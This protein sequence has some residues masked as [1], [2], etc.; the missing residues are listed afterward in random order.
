MRADPDREM[1]LFAATEYVGSIPPAAT[2][3]LLKTILVANE[4]YALIAV[5]KCIKW[6]HWLEPPPKA[7]EYVGVVM[8]SAA[9]ER[10]DPD[11]YSKFWEHWPEG[12]LAEWRWRHDRPALMAAFDKSNGKPG[13]FQRLVNARTKQARMTLDKLQRAAFFS[14]WRGYVPAGAL[15]ESRALMREAVEALIGLG[16]TPTKKLAVPIVRRCIEGF[17]ELDEKYGFITTIEREDIVEQV[18]E[19]L[20]VAGM[21]GDQ[22]WADDWRDW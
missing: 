2:D 12:I 4:I 14:G 1:S 7:F 16:R 6:Q 3:P 13:A 21:K 17:N 5:G 22:G 18:H 11:N 8:P 15:R 10:L 20:R 9:E 19:M